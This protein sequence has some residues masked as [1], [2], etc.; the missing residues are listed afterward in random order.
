M[1]KKKSSTRSQRSKS[2]L[3]P[4]IG[5]GIRATWRAVAKTLG[6]AIRVISRSAKDMDVAHQRDGFALLLFIVTLLR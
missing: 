1:A 5:A 3:L 6:S 4:A 2:R